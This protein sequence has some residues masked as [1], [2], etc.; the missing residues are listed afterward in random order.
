[1]NSKI[2]SYISR[3]L[4]S[5]KISRLNLE[6]DKN[7]IITQVLNY[8][9]WRGIKWLYKIYSEKDIKEV[10]NRPCRGLWF[11]KVLNFWLTIFNIKLKPEKRKKA[12]FE[13]KPV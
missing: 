1:M 9:D 12:I 5:Y 13:I 10:V 4:P 8:G 3:C 7:L 6:K 2:P 11:K